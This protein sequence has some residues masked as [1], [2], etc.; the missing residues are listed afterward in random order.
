[1]GTVNNL[2]KILKKSSGKQIINGGAIVVDSFNK[3]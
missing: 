1:M 2:A 3:E